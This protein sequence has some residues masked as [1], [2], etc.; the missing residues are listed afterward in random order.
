MWTLKA[1]ENQYEGRNIETVGVQA[2][3]STYMMGT[4]IDLTKSLLETKSDL[5]LQMKIPGGQ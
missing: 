5:P 2:G 3:N 4:G 1:V